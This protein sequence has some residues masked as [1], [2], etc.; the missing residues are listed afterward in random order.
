MSN[1]LKVSITVGMIS[2]FFNL[3][4]VSLFAQL[5]W[6]ELVALVDKIK[7]PVDQEWRLKRLLA[8]GENA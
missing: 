6:D 1:G 7:L 4:T 3:R 2:A 5:R 8:I